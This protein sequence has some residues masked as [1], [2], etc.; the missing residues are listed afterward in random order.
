MVSRGGIQGK[1]KREKVS[2]NKC[3]QRTRKYFDTTFSPNKNV[4]SFMEDEAVA[5]YPCASECA[6][7]AQMMSMEQYQR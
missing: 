4:L 2:L 1:G 6:N 3:M 7:P 5:Q